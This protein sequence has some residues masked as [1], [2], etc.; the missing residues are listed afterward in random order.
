MEI[1]K[2]I[3]P[4]IAGLAFAL[5]CYNFVRSSRTRR[6]KLINAVYYHADLAVGRLEGQAES[7]DTIRQKIEENESYTPY[8]PRSSA[9]D[10]TYDQIIEVMEWLDSEEE[11]IVASYFHSQLGLHALAESFTLD[12]VRSWPQKRKLQLWDLCEEYQQRTLRYA[13]NVR[14]ILDDKRRSRWAGRFV[15]APQR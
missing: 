3:T 8:G 12:F 2:L 6:R 11:R 1:T 7:N 9:D 13:R 14:S 5:S 15:R 4:I 10:L